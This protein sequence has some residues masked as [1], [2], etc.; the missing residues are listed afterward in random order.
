[1]APAK[2]ETKFHSEMDISLG[3]FGQ[4]TSTRTVGKYYYEPDGSMVYT[5][6]SEGNSNSIG[7]LGTFHQSFRPWLGYS[8]N[9][10][11]TR[12]SEGF[13]S[14]SVATWP[15][16]IPMY[17]CCYFRHGSIGLNMYELTAAPIVHGP[18]SARVDTFA[19]VG[20]GLLSFLPT[21]S[22]SPY[23]VMFRGTGVFGAGMDYKLSAH[24]ALRAEYRGL[25]YKNPDF[26]GAGG[27]TP[28]VKLINV[29]HEPTISVV[30]RLG[31]KR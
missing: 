28:A 9:M 27:G 13:S 22:P 14:G 7:V 3:V 23:R 31:K 25:L 16:S 21:D 1:M 12:L 20:G 30:Y 5:Q 4:A 8:V 19:Q 11:Y 2:P 26:A 24:W 18:R 15:T 6:D 17:P 10:G 29:T